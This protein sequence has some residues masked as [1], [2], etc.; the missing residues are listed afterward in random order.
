MNDLTALANT[1]RSLHRPGRPLVLAN[2]WD[3][4]S[5]RLVEAAG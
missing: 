2:V 3:A 1:L 5:A 4:A